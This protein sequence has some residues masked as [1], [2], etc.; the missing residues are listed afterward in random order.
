MKYFKMKIFKIKLF[1]MKKSTKFEFFF[2]MVTV[3]LLCNDGKI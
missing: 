3:Y 1:K 2:K